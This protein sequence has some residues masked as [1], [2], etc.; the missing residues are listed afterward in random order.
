MALR[1]TPNAVDMETYNGDGH[2]SNSSLM[3]GF[4]DD[5]NLNT[6]IKTNNKVSRPKRIIEDL[7][8]KS[9]QKLNKLLLKQEESLL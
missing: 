6:L 7:D 3:E 5:S 1:M 8:I 2:L 4:G 9:D